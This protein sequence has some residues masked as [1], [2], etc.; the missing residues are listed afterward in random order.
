MTNAF[1][2]EYKEKENM[3]QANHKR[4]LEME[5]LKTNSFNHK[6][7]AMQQN[8]AFL[9]DLKFKFMREQDERFH[10]RIEKVFKL[11]NN[12]KEIENK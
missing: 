8:M 3:A 4:K 11:K 1:S 5:E 7:Q 6:Q 10:K 9:W 2:Y 12:I